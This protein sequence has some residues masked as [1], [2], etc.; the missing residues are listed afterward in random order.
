MRRR[1][2]LLAA[3]ALHG[4]ASAR[5]AGHFGFGPPPSYPRVMELLEIVRPTSQN[6]DRAVSRPVAGCLSRG[7]WGRR[8]VCGYRFCARLYGTAPQE[9]W[10]LNG[11]GIQ[12]NPEGK[13]T[14]S[15]KVW[16]GDPPVEVLDF[17]DF[18]PA[19]KGCKDGLREHFTALSVEE[20]TGAAERKR[21]EE[22]RNRELADAAEAERAEIEAIR[23][24]G[25][26]RAYPML[27]IR[28]YR[29]CHDVADAF[30]VVEARDDPKY[31]EYLDSLRTCVK[32]SERLLTEDVRAA[33]LDL[34]DDAEER[35][36]DLHS[37]TIA[38]LR[39][40]TNFHQSVIEARQARAERMAG[41]DERATRLDLELQ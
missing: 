14:Y 3:I 27:A 18:Q 2:A 15:L 25:A 11:F 38:S 24:L 39:A 29:S 6:D 31:S 9:F 30:L 35:I 34:S 23:S 32:N 22:E 40:L 12:P 4:A 19:H 5:P 26:T 16:D 7:G 1:V 36:K 41:I 33:L 10:I 21:R 8:D 20:S 13:C 37:Y 17:C 28:R